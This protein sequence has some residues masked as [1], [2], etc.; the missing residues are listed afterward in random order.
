MLQTSGLLLTINED[1]SIRVEYEDYDTKLGG[2]FS[3]MYDLDKENADYVATV[4][5]LREKYGKKIATMHAPIIRDGKMKGYVSVISGKAY[6]FKQGGR[7]EVQVPQEMKDE[8]ALL[9]EGLMEAAAETS[10]EFLDKFLNSG[11]LSNDEL[12]AGVKKGLFAG[13]TIPVMGGSAIQ[14]MGVINLMNEIVAILP[15]PKERKP[16]H[17]EAVD[18]SEEGELYCD[19]EKPFAGI[20]FLICS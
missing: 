3:S 6:E 17:Y 20:K 13:D 15:S 14:N 18:G 19:T 11:W 12:I 2:D 8:I 4:N 16:I 5:A 10:E 7:E 9:K 1:D